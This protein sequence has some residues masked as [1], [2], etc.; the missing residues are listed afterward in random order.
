MRRFVLAL[1]RY[2]KASHHCR[3]HRSVVVMAVDF[4]EAVTFDEGSKNIFVHLAD[5]GDFHFADVEQLAIL[6][7]FE[8][9]GVDD[10]FFVF[11]DVSLDDH[12]EPRL[13]VV[14]ILNIHTFSSKSK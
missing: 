12:F 3:D 1:D 6:V 2:V 10:K 7:E 5:S 9:V 8:F 13:F 4:Y 14:S 11:A